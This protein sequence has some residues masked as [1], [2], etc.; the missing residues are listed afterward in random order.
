MQAYNNKI[1][2]IIAVVLLGA[3]ILGA[4]PVATA[5]AATFT[6]D[7]TADDGDNN[8]GDGTCD[9]GAGNCT[10]RAA[11]EE[12][13]ALMGAD[14]I[15]FDLPAMSTITLAN[16]EFDCI[17]EASLTI[18]GPGATQL[19]IDANGTDSDHPI[20]NFDSSSTGD[21]GSPSDTC[22]GTLVEG[23]DDPNEHSISGLTITGTTSRAAIAAHVMDNLD[24]ANLVVTGNTITENLECCGD[25]TQQRAAAINLKGSGSLMNVMVTDNE[26]IPSDT[27]DQIEGVGI[28][29]SGP[30]GEVSLTNVTIS[31]NLLNLDSTGNVHSNDTG[32]GG[33]GIAGLRKTVTL[34]N[35]TIEDNMISMNADS[36]SS[37]EDD[38]FGGAGIYISGNEYNVVIQN[39]RIEG[40][41]FVSNVDKDDHFYGGDAHGAAGLEVQGGSGIVVVQNTAITGNSTD[42]NGG[43]VLLGG[44]QT[45]FLNSS[46]TDN[47]AEGVRK[48]ESGNCD[49]WTEDGGGGGLAIVGEAQ[50]I[51]VGSTIRNNVSGTDGGGVL[52]RGAA[53]VGGAELQLIS[54]SIAGNSAG[55]HGGGLNAWAGTAYLSGAS[56]SGNSAIA[57]G[58]G[59]AQGGARME[60]EIEEQELGEHDEASYIRM[61]GASIAGNTA[62][63]LGPDCW[64]LV[65]SV[66]GGGVANTNDCKIENIDFIGTLLAAAA[67]GDGGGCTISGKGGSNGSIFVLILAVL[68][69]FFIERRR[70]AGAMARSAAARI[71]MVAVLALGVAALPS[72]ASAATFTVDSTADDSDDVAGDGACDDG[73]GNCTL[74]AAVE[75]ANEL[76]GPDTIMFD[77]P[78]SSTITLG[79]AL[80]CILESLSVVGPGET[81]LTIDADGNESW[82][83][84]WFN[85]SAD[86]DGH[87]GTEQTACGDAVGAGAGNHEIS[88]LT[89]TGTDEFP[90]IFA[91]AEDTLDVSNVTLMGNLVSDDTGGEHF[92]SLVIN[93]SGELFNVTV[94]MNEADEGPTSSQDAEGA[95]IYI[96][97]PTGR[98]TLTNVMVTNNTHTIDVT[99]TNCPDDSGGGGIS[100]SGVR[101]SVLMTNVTIQGNTLALTRA[102]ATNCSDELEGGGLFIGGAQ[103]DIIVRNSTISGNAVTAD[104]NWDDNAD[105]HGGGGVSI[106]GENW[107]LIENTM[108]TD[109]TSDKN[110]GGIFVSGSNN[111]FRNVTI[112]GNTAAGTPDASG[113]NEDGGGGGVAAKGDA[114]NSFVGG[115]IDDNV[116]ATNGGGVEIRGAGGVN[117]NYVL[118]QGTSVSD[119][120][121]TDGD[122][123][124]IHL[125]SG[126]LQSISASITGN[127]AGDD[128][129]GIAQNGPR[130]TGELGAAEHDRSGVAQLAGTTLSG[131]SA[132]D[133][134][135]E[136]WGEVDVVGG[137]LPGIDDMV[138]QVNSIDSLSGLIAAVASDSGCTIAPNSAGGNSAFLLVLAIGAAMAFERRRRKQS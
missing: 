86:P 135:D 50:A 123:G 43:G 3:L 131:N 48:S 76:V 101:K 17:D 16:G 46:I 40:N 80:P 68:G 137:S 38:E 108:I 78:S 61:Q 51:V 65:L 114:S 44:G 27:N 85:T 91:A 138:C 110:G 69:A 102:S 26:A 62:N 22:S 5:S 128:G 1:W 20:F 95:G 99:S 25:T 35:V 56:I 94:D 109:N 105:E 89:V 36:P 64:G 130:D 70:R 23:T 42:H 57:N 98:V 33:I 18:T 121:A 122:G 83:V 103:N 28:Y 120:E 11:I 63:G 55:Q 41:S 6:V 87:G 129:G 32:G 118:L 66:G 52:L 8:A 134:G 125:W 2:H 45:T 112:T 116:S 15:N 12:A 54:S 93:G 84:F 79:D 74:R 29:I 49:L 71:L 136:C 34:T 115:R 67:A 97:G 117:G 60:E 81:N 113:S 106:N 30:T 126:V 77:L 72:A 73:A 104:M 4:G 124:G 13:N 119:N 47:S 96:G 92:A 24:L 53:E 133:E 100:I 7:S 107:V 39:S 59:V 90:A 9:D 10:L 82:P 132:T 58:G 31:G 88:G 14:T 19:T 111:T 75:E 37:C 127:T 21:S